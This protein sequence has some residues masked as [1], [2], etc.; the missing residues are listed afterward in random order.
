MLK[1]LVMAA[2]VGGVWAT[3]ADEKGSKGDKSDAAAAKSVYDFT[4]KDIDGKDV[5]LT[6]YKGDVVMI[7]NVAS[8]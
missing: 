8:L 1:A 6:K 4:V 3:M 2:L 5:S 7:V